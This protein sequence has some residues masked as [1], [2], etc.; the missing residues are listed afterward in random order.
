MSKVTALLQVIITVIV[1]PL[2]KLTQMYFLIEVCLNSLSIIIN[3]DGLLEMKR[4]S[5]TENLTYP[6]SMLLS[7]WGPAEAH[8]R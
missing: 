4:D 5:R 1:L 8:S 6:G 2:N 7:S 3:K